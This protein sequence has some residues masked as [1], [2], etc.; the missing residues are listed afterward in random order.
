MPGISPTAVRAATASRR[1]PRRSILVASLAFAGMLLAPVS[2]M[3]A[4]AYPAKPVRL[5]VPYPPGGATDVIGR[6]LAQ[7]LSTTLGPDPVIGVVD[8]HRPLRG[9]L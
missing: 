4:D 2:G 1:T 7:R 9:K 5:V 8:R 3:A 6:T